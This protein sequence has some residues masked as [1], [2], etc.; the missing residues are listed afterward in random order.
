[1]DAVPCRQ[2]PRDEQAKP[3]GVGQVEVR[4]AGQPL[5]DLVELLGRDAQA[6]VLH[7]DGESVGYPLSPDLDPGG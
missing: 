6:A 1:V 7:L 4:R 5:V 3:V 2:P